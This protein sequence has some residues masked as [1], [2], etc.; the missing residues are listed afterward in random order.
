MAIYWAVSSLS[1]NSFICTPLPQSV[2]MVKV[3]IIVKTVALIVLSSQ[4]Y[5]LLPVW[6][7]AQVADLFEKLIGSLPGCFLILD[8]VHVFYLM[9]RTHIRFYL[10][11]FLLVFVLRL[12]SCLLFDYF[13]LCKSSILHDKDSPNVSFSTFVWPFS[14][15]WLVP[16]LC[17]IQV[18][19]S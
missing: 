7:E 8:H 12:A 10:H 16:K 17:C 4:F 6:A 1:P 3:G 2:P 14:H 5:G 19:E 9:P 11:G 15:L 13:V 18:R